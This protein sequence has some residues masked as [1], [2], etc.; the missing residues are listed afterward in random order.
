MLARV[1]ENIYWLGRYLERVEGTV[2]LLNAHTNM[3]MDSPYTSAKN[4]WSPL[5][6]VTGADEL[7]DELYDHVTAANVSRFIIADKRNFGSLASSIQAVRYNLR[8]CRDMVPTSLYETIN[9]LCL[10][11]RSALSDDFDTANR[12]HFLN[13]VEQHMLSIRGAVDGTMN[14]DQSFQFMRIGTYIERADM[15]S[16]ILDVR[17]ANLLPS[18]DQQALVPFENRQWESVLRSVSSLQMYR[19][20]CGPVAGADVL[21]YLLQSTTSPRSYR[22]CIDRLGELIHSIGGGDQAL[23]ELSKLSALLAAAEF[24]ELGSDPQ[25]LH[26]FVDTLEIHLASVSDSIVGSYFSPKEL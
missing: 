8:A 20:H 12:H 25:R 7:Y 21:A 4:G 6:A 11:A 24:Q 9:K 1:A 19:R 16:R 5:L 26:D 22:F 23:S 15:T 2:R 14:R 10:S 3:L 13:T 18:K 17:S